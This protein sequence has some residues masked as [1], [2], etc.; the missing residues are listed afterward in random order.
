LAL[1]RSD[2]F[3]LPGYKS[4]ALSVWPWRRSLVSF[5][6]RGSKLNN[7]WCG[8]YIITLTNRLFRGDALIATS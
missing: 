6:R 2:Q 3:V 1:E 5:P 4:G 7:D 8:E